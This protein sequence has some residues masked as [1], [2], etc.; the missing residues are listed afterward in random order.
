MRG[1]LLRTAFTAPLFLVGNGNFKPIWRILS[2]GALR[3]GDL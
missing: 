2:Y 3:T 1:I